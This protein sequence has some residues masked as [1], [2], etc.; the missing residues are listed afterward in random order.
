[1]KAAAGPAFMPLL[2]VIA[3][4]GLAVGLFAFM[5]WPAYAHEGSEPAKPMGLTAQVSHDQATLTWANPQDDSID[6]YV[7]L[8]RDKE[9]H[10][11]GTF[12]TVEHNTGSSDTTYTDGT[13]EP[14]RVYVYRVLAINPGGGRRAVPGR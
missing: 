11:E 12:E 6:G 10:R 7:I 5:V 1:M 14:E 13:V 9:I 4:L 2:A 8:R 3:S